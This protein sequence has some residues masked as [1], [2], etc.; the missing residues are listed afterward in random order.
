LSELA[1]D[2]AE[3]ARAARVALGVDDHGRVLVERDLRPVVA[4]VRLLRPHDD[5][6][7][8]L[9]L[10]DGALRRGRLHGRR[11][12]VA[13]AC[14]AP[15]RATLHTDAQDLARSRVVRHLEPR[16]LLDHFATS[17]TSA[18]RQRFVFDS[19]R[20]STMR[21]LSPTCAWFCS[22]CAWNLTERRITFL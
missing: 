20:V 19:G 8:D 7:H 4:A 13:H 15:V 11:D 9:A 22:S 14:V 2:G 3:D 6:L 21:T 18:S 10:L 17:R 12:D 5:C 1:R 16:L